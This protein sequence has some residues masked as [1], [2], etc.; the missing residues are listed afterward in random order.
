MSKLPNTSSASTAG[1][2]NETQIHLTSFYDEVF[3]L[4][5][6]MDKGYPLPRYEWFLKNNISEGEPSLVT[7]SESSSS[8]LVDEDF[9]NTH[10]NGSLHYLCKLTNDFGS[11]GIHFF[12]TLISAPTTP[13]PLEATSSTQWSL[14]NSVNTEP[15]YSAVNS[16]NRAE[17]TNVQ[18][19]AYSVKSDVFPSAARAGSASNAISTSTTRSQFDL[20]SILQLLGIGV[21]AVLVLIL[22][23]VV[24]VV[25]RYWYFHRR[26]DVK[27]RSVFTFM[28]SF[29]S[30]QQ[31]KLSYYST[32]TLS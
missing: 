17:S 22:I 15:V 26:F 23:V 9:A 32:S 6:T 13:T 30:S 5:C 28:Y 19:P 29:P 11:F 1:D 16:Q 3:S 24:V 20:I 10:G 8:L 14:Q 7:L 25:F 21:V 27:P 31:N 2:A 12:V 18:S 4:N